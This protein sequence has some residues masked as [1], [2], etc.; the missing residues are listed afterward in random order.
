MSDAL[1][2]AAPSWATRMGGDGAVSDWFAAPPLPSGVRMTPVI[3][4]TDASYGVLSASERFAGTWL[5]KS[6]P[7]L[8][9]NADSTF[10]I[11]RRAYRIA[12]ELEVALFWR[13]LGEYLVNQHYASRQGRW[14]AGRW[15]SH[16]PRAA[17]L[18]AQAEEAAASVGFA[19]EYAKCLECDEGWIADR[20]RDG[21]ER[22]GSSTA[23]P[24]RCQTSQ[25]SGAVL[26]DCPRRRVL[27][28]VVAV[29]RRRRVA[30]D[31]YYDGLR[32]RGATCCGRVA[33]C[34]LGGMGGRNGPHRPLR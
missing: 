4:R 10:C 1:R 6:C 2:A 31:D 14:P 32:R 3:V 29:E 17:D 34:P 20:V 13:N 25:G 9:V 5:P 16:G 28:R 8:H 27:R 22:S 23:C 26:A 30:Q 18:Q 33:G 15:L 24:R 19:A 12:R 21:L 7:E 11:G